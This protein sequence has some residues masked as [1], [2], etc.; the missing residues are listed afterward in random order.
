MATAMPDEPDREISENTPLLTQAE[1]EDV[2]EQEQD[3]KDLYR[4][5]VLVLCFI[6]MFL[7]SFSVNICTPAWN[8]I[9]EAIICGELNPEISDQLTFTDE[10]PICKGPDV[11]GRLAMLRGWSATIE[12]IPGIFLAMPLGLLADKWGRRPVLFL[13]FL[14]T[15]L[16]F[17][18]YEVVFLFGWPVWVVLLG[19]LWMVVGGSSA[20]GVSM[21]YTYLA[22]VSHPDEL[23]SWLFRFASIFLIGEL[24]ATPLS[25]FLLSFNA[26]YPLIVGIACFAFSLILILF[27]PETLVIRQWHDA[28]S[29]RT[30]STSPDRSGERAKKTKWQKAVELM[31]EQADDITKFIWGNKRVVLLIFPLVFMILGKF[32]QELLLQYATKRYNWTWSRAAYLVTIK[33]ASFLILMI[34]ILP[35]VSLFCLKVLKMSPMSKDLWLSRWSGVLLIIGA[36]FIAFAASPFLM[37]IGLI[38]MSAGSGYASLLRSLLNSLVEPHHVATVN[39]L[40]GFI[41]TVGLM[42]ISPVLSQALRTGVNLGGAWIGLPFMVASLLFIVSTGVV[43]A[44]KLPPQPAGRQQQ[45]A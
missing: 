18:W 41:D 44:F 8:A 13:S 29:G 1:D 39:T 36:L 40:I 35:A 21:L 2:V 5:S 12:C 20:V 14:G 19:P 43:F 24:L 16:M 7:L 25:G 34:A 33:S 42:V 26:W 32:V 4:T 38:F 22:D 3:P 27:L 15:F 17:L 30:P 9:M 10:N 31:R 23:A 45:S 11:Q 37:A 6:I 28:K